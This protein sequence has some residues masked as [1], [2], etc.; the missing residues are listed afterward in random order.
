M[1]TK[2]ELVQEET[3]SGDIAPFTKPVDSKVDKRPSFKEFFKKKKTEDDGAI[4]NQ[5]D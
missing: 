4:K 5:D 3:V 1:Q 2:K